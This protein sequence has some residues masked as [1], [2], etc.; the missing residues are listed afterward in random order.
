[1]RRREW[2]SAGWA[3]MAG[4][5]VAGTI[6]YGNDAPASPPRPHRFGDARDWFFERRFGLFVHWG[7]YS[8]GAWHE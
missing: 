3:W 1:M 6:A 5:A 7:M 8:V 4:G 2:W